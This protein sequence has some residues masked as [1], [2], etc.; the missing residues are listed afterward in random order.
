MDPIQPLAEGRPARRAQWKPVLGYVLAAALL[1]WVFHDI[2]LERLSGH[3]SDINRYWVL[4]AVACAGCRRPS[5]DDAAP[6]GRP[7]EMTDDVGEPLP[8]GEVI[9]RP[10]GGAEVRVRVE[11]AV[12][13][14]TRAR[15]LMFRTRLDA[16]AG[17]LF[18]FPPPPGPQTFWMRNTLIPLDMIFIGGDLRV[19]G[20]V[21]R[22][23][24]LT[25]TPRRVAGESQYVLEVNGG[26]AREHAIGPGAR[27]EIVGL[28]PAL[29]PQGR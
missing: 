29:V 6:G 3:I 19:V 20:V 27:I 14:E 25:E 2:H 11:F 22:T 15:G 18:V 10:I 4:A 1:V 5:G 7:T 17:M 16:D 26:F 21:E 8:T 9:V 28:D 13:G 12:K 23:E 24:P